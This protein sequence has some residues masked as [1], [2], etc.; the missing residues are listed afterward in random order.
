MY[1]HF[2]GDELLRFFTEKMRESLPES[3]HKHI[4]RVGGDEFVVFV[5]NSSF[6]PGNWLKD[7]RKLTEAFSNEHPELLLDFAAGSFWHDA[8]IETNIKE[9]LKKAD[10]LMYLDKRS[11]LEP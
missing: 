2:T 9:S 1:G 8:S 6:N 7:F 4:F 11:S 10:R 3:A 5:Q